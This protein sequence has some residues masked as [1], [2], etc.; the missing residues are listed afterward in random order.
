[1]FSTNGT[2]QGFG[3]FV[4][5]SS[6][7]RKFKNIFVI[8]LAGQMRIFLFLVFVFLLLF[9]HPSVRAQVK[10]PADTFFLL[11]KKGLLKR[12]G[13]SIYRESQ[14]ESPVKAVSPF[15][16]F[17]GKIIRSITI[18]PTGFNRIIHDTLGVKKSFAAGLADIF[19]KNTLPAV[20]RKNLFFK[21]GDKL[22]PLLLADNERY[23]RDLSFIRDALIVVQTD[24]LSPDAAD[25]III[26]RDVFSIGG[27]VRINGPEKAEVTVKDENVFGTGDRLEINSL[28]DKAR[29]PFY[30]TG[31][32]YTKKN[33]R[34]SFISLSAGF[35]TFNRAFNSGR[36][37]ENNYFLSADKPLV[38][39]YTPWT[40]N[41]T[42]SYNVTQNTYLS[43]SLYFTDFKYRSLIT[44]LWG[45]YNIG[46]RNRKEL[47]SE[48]RLRHF[49]AM[50]SFY[51]NFFSLPARYKAGYNYS[52]A[53]IN[54]LLLSYSL[55]KQNFYRTNFIY[56]FGRNE[57]V[58]EGLSG[59][60]IGGYTNKQGRKRA[61]FGLEF[62][63][64]HFSPNGGFTSYTLRS[65]T[66]RDGTTL[67][68]AD[69]LL[70]V[71]R[72]TGLRKW[73]SNL[74]SRNFFTVNVA[75][76]FNTLLSAPLQLESSFGLPYFRNS[77]DA[78]D[79][80]TTLK[81]ESVLYNTN[82][83]LGF[84]FAPFVFTD[85]SFIKPLNMPADQIKGFTA[86]GG[87]FR[88]RNE[89]LVFGTIEVKGFY[90]PRVYPG[91]RSWKFELGTNIR[92]RY[93][94]SFIRRPDFISP[95]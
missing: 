42:F 39:R 36:P 37:E 8:H 92:F 23:L 47:D 40:G 43:D 78:A 21:E 12:L 64:T 95:N 66:F 48:K 4:M 90:F 87:G 41:A 27:T 46:Y 93:N 10:E 68:D 55:Y 58:P 84:R 38:S 14:P 59:T 83:F 20:I 65:G 61:Y 44:D 62:D 75:K 30:G 56:G 31:T 3:A 17:K 67:Q 2:V 50:R 16:A 73:S 81:F 33:I 18:A 49:V 54:G 1:M 53:N 60:V 85:V 32:A 28:F 52:Y 72:F 63:A 13:K 22:L 25:I 82:R 26:T 24:S 5:N 45:G 29:S 80:R 35:K 51:H 86:L 77:S 71:S 7:M 76:Q 74:S 88:T 89:N 94:G 11:K 19:H 57:D 15:L 91:M 69:L 70:S 34:H 9:V 79:L 6:L